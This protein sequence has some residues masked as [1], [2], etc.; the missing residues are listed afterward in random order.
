MFNL[1]YFKHK[2]SF[3]KKQKKKQF[4]RANLST[5][6]NQKKGNKEYRNEMKWNKFY[7]VWSSKKK[8]H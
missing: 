3:K 1:S 4:D 6:F 7:S 2:Q 5:S 8:K